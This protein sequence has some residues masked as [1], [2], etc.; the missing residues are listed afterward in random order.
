MALPQHDFSIKV[1]AT[2]ALFFASLLLDAT[3]NDICWK[4]CKNN[5]IFKTIID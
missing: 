1:S 5:C 4:H 2:T 3:A